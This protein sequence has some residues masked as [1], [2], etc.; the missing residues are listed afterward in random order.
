MGI[1]EDAYKM[2]SIVLPRV[3]DQSRPPASFTVIYYSS[4]LLLLFLVLTPSP[5]KINSTVLMHRTASPFSS[6]TFNS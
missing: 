4:D 2:L 5:S 3:S 1:K 6:L